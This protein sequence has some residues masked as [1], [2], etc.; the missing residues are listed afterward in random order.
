MLDYFNLKQLNVSNFRNLFPK[1]LNK[2]YFSNDFFFRM[3]PAHPSAVFWSHP[4]ADA[5]YTPTFSPSR[6]SR[7]GKILTRLLSPVAA[8][9]RWVFTGLSR[10]SWL[11]QRGTTSPSENRSSTPTSVTPVATQC[12][13]TRP[14]SRWSG[15]WCWKAP[16][17]LQ[18]GPIALRS[19]G[20]WPGPLKKWASFFKRATLPDFCTRL[21]IVWWCNRPR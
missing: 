2:L 17:K 1:R 18:V 12:P 13:L 3:L 6:L 14:R 21:S 11:P 4:F 8:W 10:S 20:G 7:M 19:S 15:S 9:L 16:A 5:T